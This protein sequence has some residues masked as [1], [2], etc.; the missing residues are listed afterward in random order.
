MV[1]RQGYLFLR[2]L[3]HI[4]TSFKYS[5]PT[6]VKARELYESL[7]VT[8]LAR[9]RRQLTF[10][11]YDFPLLTV[12]H[13]TTDLITSPTPLSPVLCVNLYFVSDISSLSH[14]HGLL[15]F[16]QTALVQKNQ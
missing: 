10:S 12:Y 13:V 9:V 5:Q 6:A 14:F 1:F 2:F 15:A 11:Y 16:S 4:T 7:H 3:L 8:V